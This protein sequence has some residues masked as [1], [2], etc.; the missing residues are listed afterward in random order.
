MIRPF[1]C[2]KCSIQPQDDPEKKINP[3]SKNII[4]T[5]QSL[6]MNSDQSR[7]ACSV[8]NTM[9]LGFTG[10]PETKILSA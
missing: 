8:W 1:F 10:Y 2:S 7:F 4:F 9:I 3:K 6:K 5:F